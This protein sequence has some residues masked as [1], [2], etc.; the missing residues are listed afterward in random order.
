MK[1]F[2]RTMRKNPTDAENKLWQELR[3]K[4][5]GF[6]FRRQFVIDSKY[7]A[8]FVCLE[9]RLI[10]ECD[11]SQHQ[12]SPSPCGFGGGLLKNSQTDKNSLN[13]KENSQIENTN[14][15]FTHPQTPSA[16]EGASFNAT[17]QKP[18]NLAKVLYH[19]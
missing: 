6:S 10:I 17:S 19:S 8:D 15:E 16:R 4:K 5:L 18:F 1:E 3:N 11:G 13:L 12:K 14:A 9:K 2:S 7:I